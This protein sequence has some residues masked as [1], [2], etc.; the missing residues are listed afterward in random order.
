MIFRDI[1]EAL[2]VCKCG[3]WHLALVAVVGAIMFPR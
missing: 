2:V 1:G 3:A